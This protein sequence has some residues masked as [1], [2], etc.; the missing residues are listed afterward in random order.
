MSSHKMVCSLVDKNTLH[1]YK[2]DSLRMAMTLLPNYWWDAN[3]R[4]DLA[5]FPGPK[6]RRERAW[7]QPFAHELITV[8]FHCLRILLIYFHT[9]VTPESILK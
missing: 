5:S 7:F 1:S 2:R 4:T 6:R 3:V 9:L 8:E